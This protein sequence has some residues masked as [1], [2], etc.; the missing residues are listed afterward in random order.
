MQSEFY[1]EPPTDGGVVIEES[2][3]LQGMREQPEAVVF[4]GKHC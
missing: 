1:F 4:N 2:S 3:Y